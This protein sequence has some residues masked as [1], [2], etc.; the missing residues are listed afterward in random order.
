MLQ[1][2]DNTGMQQH[3]LTSLFAVCRAGSHARAC[4]LWPSL[5][6]LMLLMRSTCPAS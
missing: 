1:M 4:G 3:S 2:D 5:M 6:P